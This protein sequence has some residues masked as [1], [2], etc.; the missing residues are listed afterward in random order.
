[1]EFEKKQ[2]DGTYEVAE[3]EI[4]NEGQIFRGIQYF[5]P[6]RFKKPYPVIIYFHGFPQ[7]STLTEIVNDHQFLLEM[8]YCFIS[9][10]FR[11]YR[12]SEG[13]LSIRSQLSDSK[14]LI[15]FVEL[16]AKEGIFKIEDIN[17]IAHDFGAYIAI[18][19][20]S[21]IDLI[22]KLVLKSPI[23]DIQKHVNNNDFRKALNYINRFLPGNVKGIENV[24]NFIEM[25]KNELKNHEFQI[26]KAISELTLKKL[27]IIIGKEDKLTPMNEF[28]SIIKKAN[29]KPS[30]F[31]I[32]DTDHDII[33][34]TKIELINSELKEFFRIT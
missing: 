4:H 22:N 20:C 17:I 29:L 31:V 26:E 10:N 33:E 25:T 6:K 32:D 13:Q 14:R 34:D 12:F 16:M 27:K 5:P 11:G 1:V 18:I 28:N 24:K 7:L 9:I 23:L 3:I 2:F 8:G 30:I 21:Q 19:L 15:K